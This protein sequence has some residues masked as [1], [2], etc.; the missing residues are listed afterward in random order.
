MEQSAVDSPP[1]LPLT[2]QIHESKKL[3]PSFVDRIP[4][5][6]NPAYKDYCR[7]TGISIEEKDPF[8]LLVTI[9]KR[10]PS[11]FIFEPLYAKKFSA[12]DLKE[13]RKKLGLTTREFAELCEITQASI[14]QIEKGKAS[15]KEVL[16]RIEMYVHHPETLYF[17]FKIQGGVLHTDK[18]KIFLK[19]LAQYMKERSDAILKEISE[20]L[21]Y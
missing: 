3:F 10:G 16:K 13:F 8:I 1:E 18:Q 11:S 15:G 19:A 9:G 12:I 17:Q 14:V 4:S 21:S 20:L 7:A 2:K 5:R 6:E